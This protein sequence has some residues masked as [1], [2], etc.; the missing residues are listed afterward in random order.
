MRITE[1]QRERGT[2]TTRIQHAHAGTMQEHKHLPHEHAMYRAKCAAPICACCTII[3]NSR[4]SPYIRDL[5]CVHTC[6]C[7]VACL[8]SSVSALFGPH[9]R[10]ARDAF[11]HGR[12]HV[13]CSFR[14][15]GLVVPKQFYGTIFEGHV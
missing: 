6:F 4:G 8:H 11:A 12:S 14:T 13:T 3:R 5:I 15:V 9:L 1:A 10:L 2:D 7:T